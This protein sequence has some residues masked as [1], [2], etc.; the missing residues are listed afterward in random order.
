[1]VLAI[2]R[3]RVV[4]MK[5]EREEFEEMV[6]LVQE[7]GISRPRTTMDL[8]GLL[9]TEGSRPRSVA[10][11]ATRE[12]IAT[13]DEQVMRERMRIVREQMEDLAYDIS[14][15]FDR[16]LYD[17]ISGGAKRGLQSLALGFLDL[18]QQVILGQLR[19]ALAQALGGASGGGGWLAKAIG[20]ITGA[21]VGS[22]GGS[23][24]GSIPG[25]NIGP[26]WGSRAIGGPVS[27]RK[28]YVVGERG[29]EMFIP[30]TS[31]QILPNSKMGGTV[32]NH[33]NV[34]A[35]APR[36][37]TFRQKR[38]QRELAEMIGALVT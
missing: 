8:T 37:Q 35:P 30:N 16:A 26:T 23:I 15:V 18:V 4:A 7:S 25:L 32:I 11:G 38:S 36:M 1:M 24:K 9:G 33:I 13:V 27:A 20:W 29:P 21:A 6:K 19:T 28:P 10:A 3:E 34:T 14:S 2:T 12:R 31:G 22:V 5:T 17:G